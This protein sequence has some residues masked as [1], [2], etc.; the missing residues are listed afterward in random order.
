M[1]NPYTIDPLAPFGARVLGL[2][3]AL[4]QAGDAVLNQLKQDAAERGFLVFPN[5]SLPGA[6]LTSISE[7][8]GTLIARHTVH[9][10]AVHEDV[11]R[12]SSDERHGIS[13]VGA[14]W[15]SDGAIERRV[16]SHLL[17][18]A[19]RM[20]ASGGGTDFADL[21]AAYDAL[22]RR[23]Q[24]EWSRLATVNAYSG[25]VH[26]LVHAHPRTGR[27][28]L[29]MHLGMVG[30]I[31]RWPRGSHG[32]FGECA[33]R[34]ARRGARLEAMDPTAGPSLA[35]GH[36][37]LNTDEARALLAAVDARLSAHAATWTYNAQA[38]GSRG[39]LVLVDNLAV[40][41][42]AGVGASGGE[43]RILHR[44]TVEGTLPVD[45]PDASGL[46]PF[47]YI[48]GANPLADG[49]VWTGSD[50]FGVGI[51]WNRSLPVDLR[52]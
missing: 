43:L 21:S 33:E 6:A 17:F 48:W 46:P 28:S 42:R 14:Q 20:P 35:C 1:A 18:H 49:G 50:Y 32:T 2:D 10:E 4:V 3:L 11:F 36:A 30:A 22:P 39:D 44:T 5:V 41:H 38:D 31:V 13:G 45:P 26:P 24:D 37:L 25:A 16:F 15:H 9:E 34:R 8:F 29:F 40:A 19:Q 27:K 23:L 52:N 12:V 47:A 7:L 51:R